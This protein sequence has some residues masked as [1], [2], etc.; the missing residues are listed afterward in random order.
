MN[1]GDPTD[2]DSDIPL[3]R[4]DQHWEEHAANAAADP[5]LYTPKPRVNPNAPFSFTMSKLPRDVEAGT[6][7]CFIVHGHDRQANG[8]T[9]AASLDLDSGAP[10]IQEFEFS[11]GVSV[12]S[13]SR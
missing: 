1:E 2:S 10:L 3:M 13:P 4:A 12:A 7:Q 6:G 5:I 9:G 11:R 8:E